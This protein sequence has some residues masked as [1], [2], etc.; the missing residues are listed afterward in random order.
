VKLAPLA[1][2]LFAARGPERVAGLRIGTRMTVIRL[3][4]SRLL[5]H[6]PVPWE[7][8]LAREIDALGP[9]GFLV[10]PNKLHHLWLGPWV[11]A[12]PDATLYGAP[13]LRDK[14][15]DLVFHRELD[16]APPS[17]W[18]DEL[19]QALLRG[20]PR[21]NEVAFLHRAS[22]TLLLTDFAMN[23][24]EL[25]P[26]PMTRLWLRAMG[27]TGGLRTSRLIRSLVRDRAA[28]QPVLERILAWPFDRV[29][30]T[31][32]EVIERGGP[33]ALRE[34]WAPLLAR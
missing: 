19:D 5:L 11:D 31:H 27:L 34:A 18:A 29:I 1:D 4:D 24:S 14:R 22:R 25:P 2:G 15:R 3:A 32:G 6:S 20:A 33:A 21:M 17:D 23:F 28:L 7:E 8:A 13:G 26:G 10:A 16:D 30:V 12:C 9:V